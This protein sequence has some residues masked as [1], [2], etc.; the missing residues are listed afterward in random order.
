[1]RQ[2]A[3]AADARCEIH[4]VKGVF[5]AIEMALD[6]ARAGDLILVQCDTV[7]E[8]VAFV[9]DYVE[10]HATGREIQLHEALDSAEHRVQL[11]QMLES[12]DNGAP[13]SANHNGALTAVS[14]L[15]AHAEELAA[16]PS[17]D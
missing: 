11:P 5:P 6:S 3:T 16:V 10:R 17:V 9:R 13:L 12:L 4:E 7:D 15:A 1:L 14:A 8:S 2:G